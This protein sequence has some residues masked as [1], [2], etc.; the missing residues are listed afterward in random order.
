MN[1]LFE[2]YINLNQEANKDALLSV[3]CHEMVNKS[4]THNKVQSFLSKYFYHK[5]YKD[6]WL[7]VISIF[8]YNAVQSR[9]R[10]NT[11]SWSIVF[12]NAPRSVKEGNLIIIIQDLLQKTSVGNKNSTLYF[13]ISYS[14]IHFYKLIHSSIFNGR[15]S[16]RTRTWKWA[17]RCYIWSRSSWHTWYWSRKATTADLKKINNLWLSTNTIQ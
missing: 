4:E 13:L 5:S 8:S 3:L 14:I 6:T 10:Q 17:I 9:Y 1:Q 2:N 15:K 11:I 12:N 16:W 7:F